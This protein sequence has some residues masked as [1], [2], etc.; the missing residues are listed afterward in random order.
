M[1]SDYN[2]VF[3]LGTPFLPVE[4]N[5]LSLSGTVRLKLVSNYFW[6]ILWCSSPLCIFSFVANCGTSGGSHKGRFTIDTFEVLIPYSSYTHF[7]LRKDMPGLW[8]NSSELPKYL[9]PKKPVVRH[10]SWK[11]PMGQIILITLLM[12]LFH[13]AVYIPSSVSKPLIFATQ[14]VQ[15]HLW[16]R[17]PVSK[18]PYLH[19][20]LANR[21]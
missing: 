1:V 7:L 18:V 5:I 13:V 15:Q 14:G 21:E 11:I 4:G 3:F 17:E 9:G 16:N 19:I 20:F 10:P 8:T 6:N 12:Q 2:S